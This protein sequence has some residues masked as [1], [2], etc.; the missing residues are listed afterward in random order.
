MKSSLVNELWQVVENQGFNKEEIVG[1][2]RKRELVDVRIAMAH[3]LYFRVGMT[4]SKIAKILGLADHTTVNHYVNQC[5][6]R[7]D[8]DYQQ[9]MKAFAKVIGKYEDAK[10]LDEIKRVWSEHKGGMLE[11]YPPID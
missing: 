5:K 4:Q 9:M 2:S 8:Y 10:V 11:F 6:A 7:N 3:V 1:S